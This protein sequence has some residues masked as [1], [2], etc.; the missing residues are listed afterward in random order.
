[1]TPRS[2]SHEIL[3]AAGEEAPTPRA[4]QERLHKIRAMAKGKGKGTFKM[5]GTV[6][7]KTNSAKSSP[8]KSV[9][10]S[11]PQQKAK[12][13]PRKRKGGPKSALSDEADESEASRTSFKSENNGTD[14]SEDEKLESPL[15]KKIKTEI[16]DGAVEASEFHSSSIPNEV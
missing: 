1:M 9:P 15:K 5:V 13:T 11:T 6:G 2:P 12:V 7:S 8:A 14:A 16:V 3:L 4:I 10:R